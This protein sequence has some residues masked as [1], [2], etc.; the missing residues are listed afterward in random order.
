MGITRNVARYKDPVTDSVI[1]IVVENTQNVTG[2]L[3]VI[4]MENHIT[5]TMHVLNLKTMQT[6]TINFNLHI[7]GRAEGVTIN[8]Q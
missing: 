7:N 3:A 5:V 6:N 8:T 2:S 4:R 1:D